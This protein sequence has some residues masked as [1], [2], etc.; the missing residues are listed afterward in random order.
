VLLLPIVIPDGL[1]EIGNIPAPW[2]L[3]A[4]WQLAVTL[5]LPLW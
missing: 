4:R 3:F 5:W 2:E 1:I